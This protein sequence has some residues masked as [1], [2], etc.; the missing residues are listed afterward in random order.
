M[1]GKYFFI[2]LIKMNKLNR[3]FLRKNMEKT[4]Y[5][6]RLKSTRSWYDWYNSFFSN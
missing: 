3:E 1:R 6:N 2:H 4:L 5:K